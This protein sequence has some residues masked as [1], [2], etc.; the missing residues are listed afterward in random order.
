VVEIENAVVRSG[1]TIAVRQGDGYGLSRIVARAG[2]TAIERAAPI[3]EALGK[4]PNRAV[5]VSDSDGL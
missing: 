1:C 3:A 5:G 2:T 4:V